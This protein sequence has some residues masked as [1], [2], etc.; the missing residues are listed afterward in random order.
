MTLDWE[1][2]SNSDTIHAGLETFRAKVP[3]G[4]LII[5]SNKQG[6]GVTFMPDPGHE[7]DDNSLK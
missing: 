5:A 7:W 2:I 3:G 4:W 6:V 1:E